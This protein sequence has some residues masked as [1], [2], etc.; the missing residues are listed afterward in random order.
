VAMTDIF[1]K[2]IVFG[3]FICFFSCWVSHPSHSQLI[4]I[5]IQLYVNVIHEDSFISFTDGDDDEIFMN[6]E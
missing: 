3:I 1:S 5:P 4:F 2:D 6:D